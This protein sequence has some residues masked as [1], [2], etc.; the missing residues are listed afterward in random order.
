MRVRS[1]FIFAA[2]GALAAVAV[3]PA[4]AA[5]PR[6][7]SSNEILIG[8]MA[9]ETNPAAPGTKVTYGRTP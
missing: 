5:T 9:T 4:A 1:L 7:A 2:V 6:A 8:T 3:I